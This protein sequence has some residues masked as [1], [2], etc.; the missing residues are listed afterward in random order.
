MQQTR[1]MRS[2][3]ERMVAGVCGGL[4]AYLGIDPVLVRLAFFILS[5]A[6]GLGVVIYVILWII[7]PTASNVAPVIRMMDEPAG[8]PSALKTSFSPAATVGVVLILFGAFF[9]LNQMGWLH[10]AFWPLLLIG[11][12]LF[13]VIRRLWQ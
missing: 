7:M 13:F 5:L 2:E 11:A 10:G 1:L 12:G 4:S 8:D 3:T 9:L 6:S